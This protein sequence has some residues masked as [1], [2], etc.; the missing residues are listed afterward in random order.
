MAI[1]YSCC[2][3]GKEVTNPEI[4]PKIANNSPNCIDFELNEKL[5]SLE[6]ESD[7]PNW[8]I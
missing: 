2:N 8:N 7:I 5:T 1:G 6:F 4:N 3:L